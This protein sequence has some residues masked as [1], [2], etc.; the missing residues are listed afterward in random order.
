MVGLYKMINKI[1]YKFYRWLGHILPYPLCMWFIYQHIC[2]IQ[3]DIKVR[4]IKGFLKIG[5]IVMAIHEKD[6]EGKYVF[7]WL[8]PKFH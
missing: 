1:K 3:R 6:A 7:E 8:H 5:H 4:K 2:W